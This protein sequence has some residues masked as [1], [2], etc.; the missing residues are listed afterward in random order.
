MNP[1]GRVPRVRLFPALFVAVALAI[2]GSAPL[3][4]AAPM[5]TITDVGTLGGSFSIANNI[6]DADQ[7]VGDSQP[8]GSDFSHAFLY[9]NGVMTDLGTLGGS[10][11]YAYGINDSGQ[12]VGESYIPGDSYAHA[13]LYSSGVMQDLGT[14]SGGRDSYAVRI[15]NSGEIVGQSDQSGTT[16]G[17][18]FLYSDGTM[19]DLGTLYGTESNAYAINDAGE[20]VGDI[21]NAGVLHI[22]IYSEGTMTDLGTLGGMDSFARGIN[23]SGV[24]IGGSNV[25]GSDYGHGIIGSGTSMQD[26]GYFVPIDISDTGEMIGQYGN[27][28]IGSYYALDVNGTIYN[29]QSLIPANS[30]WEIESAAAINDLGDIAATAINADGDEHTVLLRQV[31]VLPVSVPEPGAAGPLSFFTLILL[32]RLKRKPS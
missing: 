18:A 27:P 17:H 29:I 26:L 30:G 23:N 19:T 32:A 8:A 21:L 12:V 11:S 15:N 2:A 14:L 20:I 24:F 16:R 25:A 9:S 6:N 31:S 1:G 13:F 3:L 7:I 4:W 5:Y 10:Q 28:S 22:F